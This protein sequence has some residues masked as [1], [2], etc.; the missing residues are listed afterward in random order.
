MK[1][2]EWVASIKWLRVAEIWAGERARGTL[3]KKLHVF[4]TVC[5]WLLAYVALFL[6]QDG[7][8]F[9]P[10]GGSRRLLVAGDQLRYL[11]IPR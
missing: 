10:S 4:H 3:R 11:S 6:G 9:R 2:S 7:L 8:G 1:V 5:F